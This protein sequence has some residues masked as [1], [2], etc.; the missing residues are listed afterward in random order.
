MDERGVNG[1]A[2]DC[3]SPDVGSAFSTQDYVVHRA[4]L[5]RG[6]FLIENVGRA[7]KSL[8]AR[9]SFVMAMPYKIGGGSGA[10]VRL[11]ALLPRREG[12]QA[13]F[14]ASSAATQT[15]SAMVTTFILTISA[16]YTLGH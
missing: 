4:V 13:V 10:P 9:G 2:V 12:E 11:V 15:S 6:G 1:L 16:Y 14:P 5:N 8:P 3:L 7:V